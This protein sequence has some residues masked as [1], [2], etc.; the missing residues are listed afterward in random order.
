MPSALHAA[1]LASKGR[2]MRCTVPGLTP[3]RSAILRTPSVR[4]GLVRAAL[5]AFSRGQPSRLPSLLAR[6]SPA[7][8]RSWIIARSNSANTPRPRQ[9][10]GGVAVGVSFD[11]NAAIRFQDQL[12]TLDLHMRGNPYEQS[13]GKTG[14]SW[15]LR[16]R[17][18]WTVFHIQFDKRPMS[19]SACAMYIVGTVVGVILMQSDK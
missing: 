11:E 7:R 18:S 12:V 6:F 10:G 1:A 19:L 8:T 9:R 2:L 4:P 15:Q 17:A 16:D 3:K 14:D 13:C 5:I